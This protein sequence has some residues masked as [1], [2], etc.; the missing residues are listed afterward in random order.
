MSQPTLEEALG[1]C[2]WNM[3]QKLVF[4][5]VPQWP[6]PEHF[7][8]VNARPAPWKGLL[9]SSRDEREVK[10]RKRIFRVVLMQVFFWI[11]R[12]R[13]KPV[14]AIRGLS[15][16]G[17]F[18]T[19]PSGCQAPGPYELPQFRLHP[20][21]HYLAPQKKPCIGSSTPRG[22]EKTSPPVFPLKSPQL[23]LGA[24]GNALFR[25]NLNLLI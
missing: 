11:L 1:F 18:Q 6:R 21:G 14:M 19:P 20:Q 9:N 13:T 3:H 8:K 22:H 10:G 15:S 25:I 16:S 4:H 7:R 12:M 5:S 23:P 2:V 24:P 17:L